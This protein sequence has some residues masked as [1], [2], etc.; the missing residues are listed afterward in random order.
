MIII[1]CE[2]VFVIFL[3]RCSSERVVPGNGLR[4]SDES[5]PQT[6]ASRGLPIASLEPLMGM[7][8]AYVL[9]LKEEII[10]QK[11]Y[12]VAYQESISFKF[13]FSRKA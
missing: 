10:R 7:W 12:F 8:K 3:H 13:D 1:F 6:R 5:M 11:Q 4:G 9:V 2:N